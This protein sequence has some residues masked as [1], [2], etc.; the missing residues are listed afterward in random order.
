TTSMPV[1]TPFRGRDLSAATWQISYTR[2]AGTTTCQNMLQR[3]CCFVSQAGSDS[4][5]FVI[6]VQKYLIEGPD[7]VPDA[8]E[9]DDKDPQDPLH[10]GKPT[11][12]LEFNPRKD[13]D[14]EMLVSKDVRNVFESNVQLA[15]Q[16]RLEGV[17]QITAM[18][19]QSECCVRSSI[20]G[21]IASGF[22]AQGI[23]LLRGAHSTFNDTSADKSYSQIKEEV[24]EELTAVG[25]NGRPWML[26]DGSTSKAENLI[27]ATVQY[28]TCKIVA[29]ATIYITGSQQWKRGSGTDVN[30]AVQASHEEVLQSRFGK[31][32]LSVG[33]FEPH[34]RNVLG[35]QIN[36]PR[37]LLEALHQCI[38]IDLAAPG[39]LD[40]V[41]VEDDFP[42]GTDLCVV[43][44]ALEE[45]CQD[46]NIVSRVAGVEHKAVLGERK[47]ASLLVDCP[48]GGKE[49][50]RDVCTGVGLAIANDDATGKVVVIMWVVAETGS[51]DPEIVGDMDRVTPSGDCH[52]GGGRMHEVE[53]PR[54]PI[55]R[56]GGGLAGVRWIWL[57]A[58]RQ[59]SGT[60]AMTQ[61]L[62][63]LA[64]VRHSPTTPWRSL[65]NQSVNVIELQA[66]TA[67]QRIG[68]QVHDAGVPQCHCDSTAY[69]HS[70]YLQ[71]GS[72]G[73]N[74]FLDAQGVESMNDD[75]RSRS[76]VLN[77]RIVE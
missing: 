46:V 65:F 73:H 56:S 21:A 4:H 53:Q 69:T 1:R 68:E 42:D 26:I 76:S 29:K 19:I 57:E 34:G 5:L 14:A 11:W 55:A 25:G 44:I 32:S 71:A 63:G 27:L 24:E 23:T 40:L 66:T 8:L 36:D 59:G 16:L 17:T 61:S 12:E 43:D 62:R 30:G 15:K 9:H 7:A 28:F 31:Q 37:G 33:G 67:S 77:Q 20:L 64:T 52:V 10:K 2:V 74:S 3:E 58:G 60:Y 72:A 6:D 41:T 75:G 18:G 48:A 51:G 47:E 38:G 22:D 13:D 50:Q 39:V 70:I 35:T 49:A 54:R 45:L